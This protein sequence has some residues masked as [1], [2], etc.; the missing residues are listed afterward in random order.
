MFVFVLFLYLES[1]LLGGSLVFAGSPE[2]LCH[3]PGEFQFGI[4]VKCLAHAHSRTVIQK[5]YGET[6]S[7]Q[8]GSWELYSDSHVPKGRVT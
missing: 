8:V 3:I 2:G 6:P 5:T 7:L 1:Q 4:D